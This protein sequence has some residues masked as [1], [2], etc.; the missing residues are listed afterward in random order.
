MLVHGG[1]RH[2]KHDFALGE[3]IDFGGREQVFTDVLL[4]ELFATFLNER[5]LSFI[6]A[7]HSVSVDVQ[8]MDLMAFRGQGQPKR[9]PYVSTS[10]DNGYSFNRV[11]KSLPI[12]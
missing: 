8:Q 7:T 4:Q 3:N 5:K 10:A 6:D 11:Q 12:E 9:D 1:A 2:E